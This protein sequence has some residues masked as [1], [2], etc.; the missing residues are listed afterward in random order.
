[1]KAL[2]G[3]TVKLT[4]GTL[5]AR[6]LRN[7]EYLLELTNAG[8]LQNYYQ[9]AGLA[10]N[11]GAKAMAH[12]GWEDPS[13]QLRGHFLGHY[14]SACAMRIAETG[15][16]ELQAK[17]D[18]IVHELARCQEENGGQWAASIPEKYL[19][20]IARGKQVWAPHYTVHKTF[21][22]LVDMYRL[23]GNREALSV[24]DR[25]A[26]WFVAYSKDR[27]REEMDDILDFETGGMLEI[28]ADLLEATGDGKY[29][30]LIER[31]YR[32][33]LFDALLEGKDVLTNMHANTTIPEVLGCARVYEVTGEEKYRDIALAYWDAAVTDRGTF[34][35]GG[36]TLGE[37]WT[38]PHR[39]G[40]RLGDRNQE[41]CTVYNMMRLA[42]FVFRQTG[43]A[44]CLRYLEKNL[45]NG[46]LAQ[47][48]Y[49]GGNRNC[50]D[51][52]GEGLITY[53]LPLRAGA[54]KGWA[55][56]FD[57]FFCCHGTLVQANA[58]HNRYL[59]YQD[60]YKLYAGIYADSCVT[61]EIDG[62]KVTVTE[63]RDTLSGSI[64]AAGDAAS[65]QAISEDASRY[66]THPDLRVITFTVN[67][68]TPVHLSLYLPIPEWAQGN[69][70]VG[71][72]SA[73]DVDKR[74]GF[75]I[76][77]RVFSDGDTVRVEIPLGVYTVPLSGAPETTVAFGYG[78]CILAGLSS[79]ERGLVVAGRD[80]AKLLAH[81]NERE[82][83]TWNDEFHTVGQIHGL[84]FI[85]LYQVGYERYQVYFPL[86][87][88]IG[89]E[90]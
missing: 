80:A 1:M 82:W 24:A 13:C 52:P 83:G 89:T 61:T 41:H 72:A 38:P 86:L 15:D 26:D 47:G 12:H 71:T 21:M 56:K 78:P 42:D 69:I 3:K 76:I 10:Q 65:N 32:G 70:R 87:T 51:T 55:S 37:I 43:M 88:T 84:R 23:T 81:D 53:Y 62:T 16:G 66:G 46:I 45:W 31:Y 7:R 39:M 35:T 11:F 50:E 34:A 27:T 59:W 58:A 6:E 18:A 40:A 90:F 5:L 77:D 8:L 57:D 22:G 64:Q 79:E 30:L 17:A 20:W 29:R 33:R 63:Q 73:A 4:D 19:A 36:Q 67:A 14:L 68:E 74:D 2:M 75:L 60:G 48:Y 54:K 9:E 44:E 25:F 49:R 28:W 85:P